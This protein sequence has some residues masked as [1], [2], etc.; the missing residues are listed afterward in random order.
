MSQSNTV[1][2]RRYAKALFE[3]ALAQKALDEVESDLN[4]LCGLVVSSSELQKLLK[5]PIVARKDHAAVMAAIL[6][7][8]GAHDTTKKFVRLLAMGRR[9][10]AVQEIVDAYTALLRNYRGEVVATVI[11]ATPVAVKKIDKIEKQLGKALDR[12]V[13][14]KVKEDEKILGGAIIR[15]GSRMLDAS[16]LEKINRIELLSKKAIASI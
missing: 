7:K 3:L 5:N 15:V 16:L 13:I 9:V 14:V 12:K 1:L 4:A 6:D 10:G 8:A 11:T 2:A